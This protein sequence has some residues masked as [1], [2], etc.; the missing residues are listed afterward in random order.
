MGVRSARHACGRRACSSRRHGCG[1]RYGMAEVLQHRMLYQQVVERLR[2]EIL[3]GTF[4]RGDQLPNERRLAERFGVSRTVIREAMKSLMQNGLVE[5][6]RG[7]GT[8]V[9][10]GTA[11]AL[12]QS[13]RMMM[14]LG[15]RER[16]TEM[17]EI[18]DILEPAIAELAA[19]RRTDADLDALRSAIEEMDASVDDA[20]AFI[21][22]DNRFH[23]ALAVA[24]GN[25]FVPRLLDSVVDLLQEL[26]GHIFQVPGGPQRGQAHHRR[27]LDAVAARD[28]VAARRAMLEHLQQVRDDGRQAVDGAGGGRAP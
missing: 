12:K 14:G 19:L 26:R 16:V 15:S 23:I 1:D 28:P 7:Q 10:D 9:V 3:D 22:A 27:I 5:V 17:V 20:G 11:D 13:F 24:T 8:F 4:R 25:V 2:Q 21:V 18:R 6:R